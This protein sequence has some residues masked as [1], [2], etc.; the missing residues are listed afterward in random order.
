M[1][2]EKKVS[3]RR[4]C[5]W[6]GLSRN[7]LNEPVLVKEKDATLKEQI[8]TL[9][10]RHKQWG[11]LKIHR[12]LRKQGELA[13]HK[14]IRRLYRLAG[15]NLRRKVKK[16]L[17]DAVRKPLPEATAFNGCWSLDFTSDSLQDGRKFRTL[18]VLDDYCR[19]ALGIEVDYSLPA[20]RVTRLLDRLVTEHGKPQRLRSDN[21][22]EFISEELQGWCKTNEIALHRIEPGRPTQNAY[23]ERFNGTFRREVLNANVFSSLAQ[24]R[25][26]VADWLVEYNTVRPHQALGFMTPAEY[27]QAA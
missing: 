4:A 7:A 2:T 1:M 8:E 3:Q 14:R 16:K 13:N 17:P 5:R 24:V 12:R 11:V 15:L 9:A 27:R 23:I 6:I 10:H 19:E 26:T 18:N 25:R 20:K 22:P 21:G